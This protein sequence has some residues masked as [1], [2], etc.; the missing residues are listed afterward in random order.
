MSYEEP[1]DIRAMEI[2][3]DYVLA[4][5]LEERVYGVGEA[6]DDVIECTTAFDE[7]LDP[8]S[9]GGMKKEINIELSYLADI[10][11]KQMTDLEFEIRSW[12]KVKSE[13]C[14][15]GYAKVYAM[16][17]N[18]MKPYSDPFLEHN[19]SLSIL[20][21][22]V[23][24]MDKLADDDGAL[25]GIMNYEDSKLTDKQVEFIEFIERKVGEEYT[26]STTKEALE[27]IEKNLEQAK[28][29]K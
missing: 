8:V 28:G 26:G 10:A 4:E 14:G 2:L 6:F 21:A 1:Q 19:E 17:D 16:V 15:R 3:Q 29:S 18:E 27:F 11:K 25:E 20:A 22:Y 12:T 23:W 5:L 9:E 7:K 13:G 24:I